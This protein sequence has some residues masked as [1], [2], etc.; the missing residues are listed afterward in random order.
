MSLRRTLCALACWGL[1]L[2]SCAPRPT[3][4]PANARDDRAD[5]ITK[6]VDDVMAQA[7]LRAVLVRVLIALFI[8]VSLDPA[9]RA[10]TRRGAVIC[11]LAALLTTELW[12]TTVVVAIFFVAYQQV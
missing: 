4:E 7:H 8:A 12:P 5:A 2:T 11:V 3:A 10:L 1:L 6:I 9:V